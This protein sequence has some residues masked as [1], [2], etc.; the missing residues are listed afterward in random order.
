M[1]R[2]ITLGEYISVQ[3]IFVKETPS[4]KVIVRVGDKTFEGKPITSS[5]AA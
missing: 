1:I 3:G 2:S 5:R 4:G